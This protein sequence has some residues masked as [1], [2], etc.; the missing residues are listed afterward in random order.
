MQI[1]I[2]RVSH[3]P[4]GIDGVLRI[5]GRRVCDTV[6]HPWRRKPVG[7]YEID[8]GTH[9]FRHGDGAMKSVNGEIIVGDMAL[10]GLVIHSAEK[11]SK[12][13]QRLKKAWQRG[14]EVKLIIRDH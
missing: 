2:K 3:K 11:Y 13:Y 4:W 7:T 12:L 9:P 1:V 6:E 10:P 8:L 5:N 14:T